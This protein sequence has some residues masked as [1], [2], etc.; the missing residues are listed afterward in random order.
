LGPSWANAL[1]TPFRYWKGESFRGG[2]NTPFIVHWPGQLGVAAGSINQEPAH[3]IDVLPTLLEL[4]SVEYPTVFQGNAITPPDGKSLAPTLRGEARQPHEALFFEHEGGRA[5]IAGG[6]KAVG[7][8][9][10]QEWQLYD[11]ASDRS[12]T[13]NVAAAQ[14]A[15]VA[16]LRAAWEDWYADVQP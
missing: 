2:N 15:R 1:N 11:L 5:C 9:G 14:P 7:L 12:E 4:A 8:R 6:F 16:S 3:V 10:S 13:E